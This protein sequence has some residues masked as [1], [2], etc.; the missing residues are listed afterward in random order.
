VFL[1]LAQAVS[2]TVVHYYTIFL[3]RR[4]GRDGF[5]AYNENR[6]IRGAAV[7]L[8]F[9]YC[10]ASLIFLANTVPQIRQI[11]SALR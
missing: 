11:L 2:V 5:K 7:G 10:S 4:L 1:G 8:T 9:C 6:W 3:K